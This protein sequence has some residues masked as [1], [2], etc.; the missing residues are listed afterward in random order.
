MEADKSLFNYDLD[1]DEQKNA[2]D[3]LNELIKPFEKSTQGELTLDV[4][5]SN[6]NLDGSPAIIY[7]LYVVA[8]RLGNYRVK[9]LS[10]A[11]GME[12][13][14]VQIVN[15]FEDHGVPHNGIQEDVFKENILHHMNVLPVK[16]AIENLFRQSKTNGRDIVRTSPQ[17]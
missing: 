3:Y 2:W 14:P 13:F 9:V 10:V 8:P 7:R 1:Q 11:E 16:K 15:H 12:R 4:E 17:L 6:G 5:S